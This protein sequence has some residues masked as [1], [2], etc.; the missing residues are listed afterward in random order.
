MQLP[1]LSLSEDHVS[2]HI[3]DSWECTWAPM[4]SDTEKEDAAAAME[5]VLLLEEEAL[6]EMRWCVGGC[7]RRGRQV[8]LGCCVLQTLKKAIE[9]RG[10]VRGEVG[11]RGGGLSLA[12]CSKASGETGSPQAYETTALMGG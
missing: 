9:S 4:P 2:R 7:G 5:P 10:L 8:R 11:G 12:T 1:V 3:H 6:V